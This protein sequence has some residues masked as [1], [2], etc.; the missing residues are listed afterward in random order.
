MSDP[1]YPVENFKV[2]VEF[3]GF[4]EPCRAAW[5]MQPPAKS[6][7]QIETPDIYTARH[8]ATTLEATI[9]SRYNAPEVVNAAISGEY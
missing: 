3:D 2:W 1:R 7:V 5:G 9:R 4:G 6:V 8:V